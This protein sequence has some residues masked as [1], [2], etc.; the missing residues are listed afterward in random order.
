MDES[1]KEKRNGGHDTGHYDGHGSGQ[2]REP[3]GDWMRRNQPQQCP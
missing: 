1:G 2:D 3:D